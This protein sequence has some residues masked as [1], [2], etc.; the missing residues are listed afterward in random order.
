M[1]SAV[2]FP[3]DYVW[4]LVYLTVADHERCNAKIDQPTSSILEVKFPYTRWLIF[5]I[6]QEKQ[7]KF[8]CHIPQTTRHQ[9]NP[10]K[11]AT[12]K[13]FYCENG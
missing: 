6:V 1:S 13:C 4:F 9:R 7:V 10:V 11:C 5:G 2:M 3:E 8:L 12:R